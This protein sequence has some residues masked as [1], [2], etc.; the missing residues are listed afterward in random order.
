[1][2]AEVERQ[3][4]N[5]RLLATLLEIQASMGDTLLANNQQD[6]PTANER[7]TRAF[8]DYV[9]D[10]LKLSPEEGAAALRAL[11]DA[12]QVEVA[13]AM[14]FWGYVRRSLR[15]RDENHLF[16]VSRLLDPDPLRNRLRDALVQRDAKA[17]RAIAVEMAPAAQPAITVNLVGVYLSWLHPFPDE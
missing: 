5:Q 17:L 8:Q 14:D 7:Y 11:G 2:L 4:K 13:S 1:L 10:L 12:V 6:C 9:T 16:N 3:E 15:K